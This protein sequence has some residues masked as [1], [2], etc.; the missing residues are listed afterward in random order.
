[1]HIISN[2][3]LIC[4]NETMIIQLVSF[5]IFLFIINRL[6]FRPLIEEKRKRDNYI[7]KIKTDI[8]DAI[9]DVE[10]ITKKIHSEG[11]Q[12]K[13]EAMSLFEELRASGEQE[14]SKVFNSTRSK[15]LD[16]KKSAESE[17]DQWLLE[18]KK[19]LQKEAENLSVS[20]M[21]KVLGRRLIQ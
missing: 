5:L 16:I 17:I 20:I 15:I 6:M 9:K 19:S 12:A 4:I 3:A 2:V 1:M 10:D 8:A 14:A 21:E 13:K 7:E 11:T 18:A